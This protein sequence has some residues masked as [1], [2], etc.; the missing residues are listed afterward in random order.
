MD[1]TRL[2]VALLNT[3]GLSPLLKGLRPM[4]SDQGAHCEAPH[5]FVSAPA[6]GTPVRLLRPF[7]KSAAPPLPLASSPES[8]DH[9][10]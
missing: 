3:E 2:P 10:V 9:D 1:D 5:R 7:F 8:E 6:L 4:H